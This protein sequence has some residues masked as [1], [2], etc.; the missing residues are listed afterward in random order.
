LEPPPKPSSSGMLHTICLSLVQ[1][2]FAQLNNLM[3]E[4]ECASSLVSAARAVSDRKP[5]HCE[6][7]LTSTRPASSQVKH[8]TQLTKALNTGSPMRPRPPSGPKR[9][10]V[11]HKVLFVPNEE[12]TH[13]VCVCARERERARA[14]VEVG[15][16]K[17]KEKRSADVMRVCVS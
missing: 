10:R 16:E 5:K 8:V 12:I 7:C 4:K 11:L 1:F 15:S 3:T 2:T 9:S 14:R 17:E 13:C 6:A